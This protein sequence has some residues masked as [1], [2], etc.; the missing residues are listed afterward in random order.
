MSNPVKLL[1]KPAMLAKTGLSYP[2]ICRQIQ[3]ETFPKPVQLGPNSVAWIEE[4]IDEWIASRPRGLIPFETL[5]ASRR[6]ANR[7][8]NKFGAEKPAA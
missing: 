8:S 3:T 7:K 1:R 5:S 6:Y 2:T 4:E